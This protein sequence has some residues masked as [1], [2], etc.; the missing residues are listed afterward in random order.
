MNIHLLSKVSFYSFHSLLLL[1]YSTMGSNSGVIYG[2][3]IPLLLIAVSLATFSV[4]WFGVY[5]QP[6]DTVPLPT[7][8]PSPVATPSPISS[9]P[10]PIDSPSPSPTPAPVLATTCTFLGYPT[11]G[12]ESCTMILSGGRTDSNWEIDNNYC[13]THLNLPSNAPCLI[14]C[15]NGF[16][17]AN[18]SIPLHFLGS[19]SGS[20]NPYFVALN[21]SSSYMLERFLNQ[22]NPLPTNL[23]V[24]NTSW[25]LTIGTTLQDPL[26]SDI[27]AYALTNEVFTFYLNMIVTFELGQT[28]TFNS[29]EFPACFAN[30]PLGENATDLGNYPMIFIV[31]II[32]RFLTISDATIPID[33][34]TYYC[35][36]YQTVGCYSLFSGMLYSTTVEEFNAARIALYKDFYNLLHSYN[37]EFP[38]CYYRQPSGLSPCW[39]FSTA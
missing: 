25:N 8:V 9:S 35:I 18:Q 13:S 4:L 39:V 2:I 36:P 7:P 26:P 20:A 5:N 19:S 22:T 1:L 11:Y 24:D 14:P 3:M 32:V 31:D 34:V 21:F 16:Y 30:P 38:N 10:S 29:T 6:R 12:N 23:T 15:T 17:L 33:L 27:G 37:T 28:L